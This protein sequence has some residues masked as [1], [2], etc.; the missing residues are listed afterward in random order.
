MDKLQPLIKHRYW[1]CFGFALIFALTAWLLASGSIAAEID[2][3]TASVKGSFDK[4]GQGKD[5]PNQ[6]WVEAAKKKNENDAASYKKA[7]TSLRERQISARRWP[8]MI[9]E[10]MKGIAYQEVIQNQLTREKWAS[11]YRDEVEALLEIVKPFRD[12][13]GL[14]VVDSNR[15]THRPYNSWITAKPQSREI[16]DAQE[17]IWLLRSL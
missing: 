13:K 2:A 1:I 16:W 14:V 3:R 6:K 17:D 11:I 9:S 8:D 12:G 10:E 15:I 5:Q 7:A 4:S